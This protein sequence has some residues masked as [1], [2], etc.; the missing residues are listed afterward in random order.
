MTR[1]SKTILLISWV[2]VSMGVWA[3]LIM[4]FLAAQHQE[5]DRGTAVQLSAVPGLPSAFVRAGD[6]VDVEYLRVRR[7]R[8]EDVHVVASLPRHAMERWITAHPDWS[9]HRGWHSQLPENIACVMKDLGMR[10]STW[11]VDCWVIGTSIE[12][13]THVTLA[14]DPESGVMWA[15]ISIWSDSEE[16]D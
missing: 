1:R 9:V 15:S 2:V 4:G 11:S 12:P 14:Y 8:Y 7:Y 13:N 16:R 3:W 5:I 10:G 6:A